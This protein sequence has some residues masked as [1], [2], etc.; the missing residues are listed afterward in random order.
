MSGVV[1]TAGECR[2]LVEEFRVSD[3]S[4]DSYSFSIFL[5]GKRG[6]VNGVGFRA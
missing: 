5:V 6:D 3:S 4:I 1:G 2:A